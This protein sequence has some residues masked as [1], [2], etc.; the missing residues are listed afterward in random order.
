M[1][2]V[3]IINLYRKFCCD[4]LNEYY[5]LREDENLSGMAMKVN[6]HKLRVGVIRDWDSRWSPNLHIPKDFSEQETYKV[7]SVVGNQKTWKSQG[8]NGMRN[9]PRK[10][11]HHK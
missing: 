2:V 9:I 4:V 8:D 5:Q 11:P 7:T 10:K 3:V 1:L 6:P